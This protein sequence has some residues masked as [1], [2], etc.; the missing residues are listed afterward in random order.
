MFREATLIFAPSL[1]LRSLFLCPGVGSV[2]GGSLVLVSLLLPSSGWPLWPSVPGAC[3]LSGFVF[4]VSG[5]ILG[6]VAA[7]C[8]AP[9]SSVVCNLGLSSRPIC[10]LLTVKL[11]CP[12]VYP[13][14]ISGELSL[15]EVAAAGPKPSPDPPRSC[16]LLRLP[17]VAGPVP[18]ALTVSCSCASAVYAPVC[19]QTL[20]AGVL[21]GLPRLVGLQ[22]GLRPLHSLCL[23][24][25]PALPAPPCLTTAVVTTFTSGLAPV[26]VTFRG[27]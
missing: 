21:P 11:P 17:K 3:P 4:P 27:S 2:P 25:F 23:C 10:G 8:R 22:S 26:A 24:R 13:T 14:P 12:V 7:P 15:G 6:W 5:M 19:G 20:G 18:V 9:S 1:F 16:R